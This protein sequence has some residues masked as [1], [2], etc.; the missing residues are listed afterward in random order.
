M[1]VKKFYGETT[2]EAVE[3]V[4]QELG[5]N[6]IILHEKEV[7]P[8][9]IWRFFK[10]PSVEIVAAREEQ[11]KSKRPEPMKSKG[12][13]PVKTKVA[14]AMQNP[15]EEGEEN[16]AVYKR[17]SAARKTSSEGEDYQELSKE[18]QDMKK[19]L[20]TLVQEKP[21]GNFPAVL[22]G[23]H[24]KPVL[25]LY[26]QLKLQDVQEEIIIDLIRQLKEVITDE[27]TEEEQNQ[28]IRQVLK[29][30]LEEKVIMKN[31]KPQSK[32]VVFVGPTGVGKTTTIAKLAARYALEE[33]K[34]LGLVSAD[35]YRI[36][37]VEQLK[38]YSEILNIPIKIVYEA[39]E[40]T[41][42]LE[43]F[44]DRDLVLIDT[45]GRSHRNEDQIKE[46]EDL[47]FAMED[48]DIYL[49]LS[50]T[51]STKDLREITKHYE[52]LD[53][54]KIIFTKTDEATTYGGI[55]NSSIENDKPVLYLTNGQS[56]PDDIENASVEKLIHL[57][58]REVD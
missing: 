46:L 1:K 15:E 25:D 39:K 12:S 32:N 22:Q 34:K 16:P 47:L 41:E 56:V 7:L 11:V 51:S 57:F 54:Y 14:K 35:T 55:L 52:F 29:H 30:K 31:F 24:Q 9:G 53:N 38:T 2:E 19:L 21:V 10:S 37:A 28:K 13:V 58:T 36:A 27:D 26:K 18:L 8:R 43:G 48:K 45:A 42:T 4:K 23:V 50:A 3:K 49:V 33:G 5:A 44:S 20:N 17:P 40:I 6:A